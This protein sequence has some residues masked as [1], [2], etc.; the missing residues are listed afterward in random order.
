MIPQGHRRLFI[1]ELSLFLG[2]AIMVKMM[3]LEGAFV[4]V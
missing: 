2:R 3:M 1:L 4:R